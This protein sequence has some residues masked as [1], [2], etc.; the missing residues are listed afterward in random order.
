M[1][2]PDEEEQRLRSTAL[3]T[4]QSILYARQRAEQ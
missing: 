3:Q 4:M 2:E 1:M